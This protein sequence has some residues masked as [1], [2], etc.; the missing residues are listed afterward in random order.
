MS[1]TTKVALKI[2]KKHCQIQINSLVQIISLKN[3]IK[4]ENECEY[5]IFGTFQRVNYIFVFQQQKF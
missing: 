4:N 1:D 2:R 5:N 3:S